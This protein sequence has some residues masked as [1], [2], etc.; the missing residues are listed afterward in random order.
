MQS[1]LIP[2][3]PSKFSVEVVLLLVLMALLAG[4]AA[5]RESVTVDEVA[6]TAAGVSYLQKLDLR[7]NPEHPPLAKVIAAIPLVIRGA[8]AD[9]SDF[10]WTFSGQSTFNQFIGEWVFGND[11]LL[12]WNDAGRTLWWARV[13]MLL[14]TL[15]LGL[16]LYT[17]G[18]QL[19][20]SGW[21]GLLT[22]AVFISY[23]AFLAFGPLVITDIAVALFWV[24]AVWQMPRMW[25][26]P[27]RAEIVKLGL[28]MSGAFLSKYSSGL[29]LFVFPAVA[30]SLRLRPLPEQP[31]ETSDL[32]MWRR[33]GRRN[34]LRAILWAALFV[35][36]VY[37]VL[38]WNQP[39]D[40]FNFIPHF[41]ASHLL[42][43]LLMPI[44]LY[45]QGVLVFA[46]S[47]GS[48]PTFI[49]G[50]AYAH[51]VW[52]Y[53]PVLFLLKSP[54]ALLLLIALA[55]VVAIAR[56]RPPG[57]SPIP[58][59]MEL[60]WRCIWVSLVVF[61]A[62]CMLNRLD[63][64]IRHFTIPLTLIFLLLAPLP[65]TLQLFSGEH[66]KA[67]RIASLATI[68]LAFSSIMT[69]VGVYPNFFPFLNVLSMG[70]PGYLLVNDSNLD[71][72][73]ALP[74]VEEFVRS[75]GLSHVLLDHYG[76]TDPQPFV[77]QAQLW[78]CQQPHPDDAGHWAFVSAN[79][80]ADGS[81]CRWLF[82]YVHIELAGGS[83]YAFLLPD[84]IPPPGEPGGPPLPSDYRYFGGMPALNNADIRTV[85]YRCIRDPQQMQV[86]MDE[87]KTAMQEQQKK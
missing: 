81:N 14:I 61:T 65:R 27:T 49:L 63:I 17:Y 53:F 77:P 55:V 35:Y 40:S 42:R 48:R 86:V 46:L 2:S 64:S 58:P 31:S 38:S 47:A 67:A 21:G 22:L 6:H 60:H 56:K 25:Q 4:G 78:D 11:F 71:W 26:S 76:F 75:R 43:R 87:F 70:K 1:M 13:P 18:A 28:A 5:R 3:E 69:A 66:R 16:A 36:V 12:R 79:L 19:G 33:R 45:L 62:A 51:G 39:T 72:G 82:R 9:Y 41:P 34:I 54:F 23:P 29:L 15:L 68:A 44:W 83:M 80:I 50:H 85:F 32:K 84:V 7:M 57:S 52:F 73:H 24:L 59:G 10:S 37:F 8:R 74:K 20:G 30:L